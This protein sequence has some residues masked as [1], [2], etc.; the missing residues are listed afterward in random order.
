M[1]LNVRT[2]DVLIFSPI[3]LIRLVQKTYQY[4]MKMHLPNENVL[5]KVSVN[6]P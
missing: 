6:K 3:I 1:V 4:R 5:L 2:D